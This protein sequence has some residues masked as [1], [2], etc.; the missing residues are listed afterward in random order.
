MMETPSGLAAGLAALFLLL[1]MI[2]SIRLSLE[3][4]SSPS[5]FNLCLYII[6]GA[7]HKASLLIRQISDNIGMIK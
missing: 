5:N 4:E 6:I 3:S 2:R 1:L 7:L